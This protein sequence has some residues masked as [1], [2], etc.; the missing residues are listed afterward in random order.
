VLGQTLERSDDGFTVVAGT[1]PE[2]KDKSFAK[3]FF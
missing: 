3:A 1:K 2:K